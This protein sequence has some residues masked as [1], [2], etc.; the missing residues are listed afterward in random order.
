MP[1]VTSENKAEF[2]REF[3][4]KK[5][6]KPKQR[7]SIRALLKQH[8]EEILSQI[9]A[10]RRLSNGDRIFAFHEQ[11][12]TPVEITSVDGLKSYAPDLLMALPEHIET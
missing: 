4:S 8:G 10:E 1:T 7:K 2:D 5:S 9:D 3:M 12:G 11:G 6:G